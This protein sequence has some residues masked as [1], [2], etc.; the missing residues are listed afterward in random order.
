[1]NMTF[2]LGQRRMFV[3]FHDGYIKCATVLS[4][5]MVGIWGTNTHP[6]YAAYIA[7]NVADVRGM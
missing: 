5:N 2:C 6:F 1:M 3:V 7:D 4:I